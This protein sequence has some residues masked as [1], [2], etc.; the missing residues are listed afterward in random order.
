MAGTR[1]ASPSRMAPRQPPDQTTQDLRP[2]RRRTRATD[3][4]FD[5]SD[6]D[7]PAVDYED[8]TRRTVPNPDSSYRPTEAEEA[9][10]LDLT[11]LRVVTAWPEPDAPSEDSVLAALGRE[12][13][14][15]TTDLRVV[16]HGAT[17]AIEGSVASVRDRDELIALLERV[18]GVEHVVATTLRIR[19]L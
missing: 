3:S 11:G 17:L 19:N 4:R 8:L 12:P 10:A 9:L 13:H 1:C 18:P 7:R 2:L 14:L 5:N 16:I 15:D 6:A